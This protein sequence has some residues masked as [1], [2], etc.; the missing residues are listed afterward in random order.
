MT[1]FYDGHY[2]NTISPVW[3]LYRTVSEKRLT[4]PFIFLVSTWRRGDDRK[5]EREER[6]TV[7]RP[8]TA[9]A[10]PAAPAPAPPAPPAAA[11]P[12]PAPSKE[13]EKDGEKEKGAW[14]TE[15]DREA[16][17]RTKNETDED[18]WTTVRR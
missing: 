7:R 13:R 17:R 14:R 4:L 9:P 6:E 18:G 3:E 15:K 1:V 2:N 10:P 11:P 16:L 12:A 8:T 5:E